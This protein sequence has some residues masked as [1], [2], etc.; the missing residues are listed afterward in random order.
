MI[1]LRLLPHSL[2]VL[3]AISFLP[4][5]AMARDNELAYELGGNW[6][7]NGAW[8]SFDGRRL[9][10]IIKINGTEVDRFF[11]NPTNRTSITSVFDWPRPWN[12]LGASLVSYAGLTWATST[13]YNVGD[14]A[15]PSPSVIGSWCYQ[16]TRAGTSGD[17]E[18]IWPQTEAATVEDPDSNGVQWTAVACDVQHISD[19]P[20]ELKIIFSNDTA[21]VGGTHT[22][23]GRC[24]IRT[25]PSN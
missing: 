24:A 25:S 12:R 14:F 22:V 1:S 2:I 9:A 19:V 8:S 16:C 17:T 11:D 18:P 10:I 4:V 21:K 6:T 20:T 15:S 23:K 7:D 13:S 5:A 3:L